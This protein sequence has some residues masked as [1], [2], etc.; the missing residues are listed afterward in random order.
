MSGSDAPTLATL[1]RRRGVVRASITRLATR[2]SEL[3]PRAHE[4]TTSSLAHRMSTKLET[5]DSDFKIHH[6]AVIDALTEGDE[7]G[8]A[9]EQEILDAHDDE[10]ASLTSRIKY[11]LQMCSSASESGTRSIT[12]SRL[13]QLKTR[14]SMTNSAIDSLSG[15]PQDIHLVHLY[16]EQLSDFK[17]ELGHIRHEVTSQCT[18][19]VSDELHM[20]IT[21]FDKS[22]FDISLK[23]NKLL[24]NPERMPEAT[25]STHDHK[26][27]QAP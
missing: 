26:G 14:L 10:V 11:L 24:Y 2:L 1:R 23:V 15:E 16:Q 6:L 8:L 22:I 9:K 13:S 21:T 18:R 19:D 4:T 25:V 7:D 20:K 17:Q 3:E 27:C 5:L 12:I